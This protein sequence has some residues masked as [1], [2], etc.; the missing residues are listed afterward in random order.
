MSIYRQ[1]RAVARP[2]RAPETGPVAEMVRQF[3]DPY[4]FL[5]E[6]VQN[7]IDADATAIEARLELASDGQVSF[8]VSDDGMGMDRATIEGPLLTLFRTSKD[9]DP[10]KIGR[11]GVGF[12]SVFAIEPDLVIVSTR[13]GQE[14]WVVRVRADHSYELEQ[15]SQGRESR[16]TTVTVC[17][18]CAAAEFARHEQQCEA[19]LR[20]WCRHCPCA[21][22]FHV[23]N[24]EQ[25]SLR[26]MRIDRPLGVRAACSVI[27]TR[28]GETFVVGPTA[29][30]SLLQSA[31]E[32]ESDGVDGE[33]FA[34]FYNRGLTLLEL[35]QV[36]ETLRGL[37]CKVMSPNLQ[38]TISRDDVRRDEAFDKTLESAR[39]LA[40]GPLRRQLSERLAQEAA[41][42]ASGGPDTNYTALLVAASQEPTALD[43]DQLVLPLVDPIGDTITITAAQ[44]RGATAR[45]KSVLLA[46]E[47]SPLT[48]AFA[49]E[50]TPV[51]RCAQQR[52]SST[53]ASLMHPTALAAAPSSFAL[54]TELGPE[55]SCSDQQF[56]EQLCRCLR[57]MRASILRVTLARVQGAQGHIAYGA[58]GEGE[59]IAD[60]RAPSWWKRWQH[61]TT[62]WLDMDHGVVALARTK[63]ALEAHVSASLLARYLLLR[64][65][66]VLGARENDRLIA[67]LSAVEP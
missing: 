60:V 34:G 59:A 36:P 66:G 5:R 1:A 20:K 8:A 64:V 13:C 14:S 7:A 63:A 4:A 56:C 11:Y 42:V 35:T 32:G 2:Q 30:S 15:P 37:R 43:L 48:R 50:S 10:G 44:L 58:D 24:A 26:S 46:T 12:V 65:R 45:R 3:A 49:A 25:A 16:G 54:L 38:H 51:V 55:A 31:E 18:D 22:H 39:E 53:L 19:A 67:Q 21:L 57:A 6:L 40:S 47:S 29:G 33:D 52:M 41:V 9:R 27:A 23:S 28:D 17:K 62:L 61:R